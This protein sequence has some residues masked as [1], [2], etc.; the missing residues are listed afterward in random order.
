MLWLPSLEGDFP[1]I[2]KP[3]SMM[4]D[5]SH[6]VQTATDEDEYEEEEEELR[7]Q[8]MALASTFPP[9]DHKQVSSFVISGNVVH[10][11]GT[12]YISLLGNVWWPLACGPSIYMIICSGPFMCSSY[13]GFVVYLLSISHPMNPQ[14][15]YLAAFLRQHRLTPEDE[16][17]VKRVFKATMIDSCQ[18][19]LSADRLFSRMT[20]EEYAT[21]TRSA[22]LEAS[23]LISWG[24]GLDN[25]NKGLMCLSSI[26]LVVPCDS[27]N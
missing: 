23:T 15:E 16:D 4:D 22:L 21:Y 11:S 17:F 6:S 18:S 19:F 5:D 20:R 26:F 27:L 7:A 9:I 10:Q 14:D 3:H 1:T 24:K 13:T 8:I 2:I 25:K 12:L